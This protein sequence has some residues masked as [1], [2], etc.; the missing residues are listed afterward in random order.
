MAESIIGQTKTR[1][2]RR[3]WVRRVALIL[4]AASAAIY[5]LIGLRV[6]EVIEDDPT[7]QTTFGLIAGTAFAIGALVIARFDRRIL[8]ALGSVGLAFVIW[9][10]FSVAGDRVPEYEMWGITLRI[11]QVPLLAALVYLAATQPEP[12]TEPTNTT[13]EL[14]TQ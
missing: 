13:K 4:T 3:Q 10:Y 2:R 12:A 7:G 14:Q 1:I 5:Y 8:W 11:L 9:M 6:V